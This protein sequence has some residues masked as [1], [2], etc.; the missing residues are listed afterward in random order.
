MRSYVLGVR[1]SFS[2]CS[3]CIFLASVGSICWSGGRRGS[4]LYMVA[5]QGG[6]PSGRLTAVG[7]RLSPPRVVGRVLPDTARDRGVL[8]LGFRLAGGAE[9]LR[10]VEPVGCFFA[11]VF[12]VVLNPRLP[13][14]MLGEGVVVSWSVLIG[15]LAL[16][17]REDRSS[18]SSVAAR[19][20]GPRESRP[21]PEI[22]TGLAVEMGIRDALFPRLG[23][24]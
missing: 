19:L 14:R 6:S 20:R 9:V 7:G 17:P 5:S 10:L 22:G 16:R 12:C 15:S 18:S 1:P 3:C 13:G 8:A 11:G 2:H 21:V 24:L 23:W 4:G